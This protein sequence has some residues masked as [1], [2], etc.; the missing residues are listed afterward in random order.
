MMEFTSTYPANID[1][2]LA[3]QKLAIIEGV[4][5]DNNTTSIGRMNKQ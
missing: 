2:P 3:G 5:V 1:P 4:V